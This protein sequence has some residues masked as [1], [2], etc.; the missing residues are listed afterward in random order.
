MEFKGTKTPWILRNEHGLLFVESTKEN[1]GTPYGQEIMADDYFNED[2]KIHDAK[3]IAA[4]PDLLEA[5]Q[6]FIRLKDLYIPT[7]DEVSKFIE[8]E[9]LGELQALNNAV[10]QAEKAIEKAL[11]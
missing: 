6:G 3:L 5:L 10:I 2:E 11:K 4:A 9:F 8:E 1:L 7:D